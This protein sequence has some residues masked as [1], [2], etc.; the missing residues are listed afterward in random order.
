MTTLSSHE[1]GVGVYLERLTL[2]ETLPCLADP[3]G[4]VV[5]G[6]PSRPIPPV[7]PYVNAILPTCMAFAVGL[8][9]G[10]STLADCGPLAEQA[11]PAS[12]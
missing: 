10:T 2:V 11:L 4:C 5:V 12:A 9:P 6:R 7:L 3:S 1:D 8:L